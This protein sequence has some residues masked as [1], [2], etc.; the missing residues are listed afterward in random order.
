MYS[1]AFY[2]GKNLPLDR[3]ATYQRV[4]VEPENITPSELFFLKEKGVSVY[5]YLSIGEVEMNTSWLK[6]C[7]QS[8]ILGV[9][10]GWNSRV[11]D[12]SNNDWCDFLVHTRAAELWRR[13]Y[14]GFFLDTMD[15]YQLFTKTPVGLLTQQLG[16]IT[17]IRSINQQFLDVNL[18]FNR[19][20]EILDEVSDLIDGLVAESLFT[21][22]NPNKS[23]YQAVSPDNRKWLLEKLTMARD[24]YKLP[25]TVIDYL[26]FDQREQEKEIAKKIATLGFTPWIS[27]MELNTMGIGLQDISR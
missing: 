18:L 22:W 23:Q 10:K 8:W 5:A 17:L 14:H 16:I 9:N 19:G 2:Y 11:M 26:P 6:E 27:T 4:V 3:L 20:F 15:S 24:E 1:T 25:I 21:G 13:G 7:N 12:M